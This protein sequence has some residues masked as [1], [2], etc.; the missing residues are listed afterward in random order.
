MFDTPEKALCHLREVMFENFSYF[1]E[2]GGDIGIF[3]ELVFHHYVGF[4]DV[5]IAVYSGI[6]KWNGKL[7]FSRDSMRIVLKKV[8]KDG[9]R[10]ITLKHDSLKDVSFSHEKLLQEAH[11][12]FLQRGIFVEFNYLDNYEENENEDPAGWIMRSWEKYLIKKIELLNLA[13]GTAIPCECGGKVLAMEPGNKLVDLFYSDGLVMACPDCERRYEQV[14]SSFITG[15]YNS[16]KH[17]EKR[18]RH[19]K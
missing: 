11:A 6:I 8:G 15:E 4:A 1:K 19:N 18:R 13:A 12:K 3:N 14:N 17:F 9:K 16:F 7:G 10:L 2:Y 5:S